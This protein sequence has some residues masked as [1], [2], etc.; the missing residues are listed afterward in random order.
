ML[1][2]FNTIKVNFLLMS[3]PSAGIPGWVAL[4]QAVIQAPRLLLSVALPISI[5]S[6]ESTPFRWWIWKE[7][8]GR[9]N[10][11]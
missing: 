10:T 5:C 8:M 4:L 3:Q 9:H 2:W 7:G 1:L 6:L 11:C